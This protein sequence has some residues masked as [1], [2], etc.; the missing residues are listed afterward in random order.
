M[1]V[2]GTLLPMNWALC[3]NDP[4]FEDGSFHSGSME[5]VSS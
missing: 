5:S 4:A 3:G 2:S 1:I